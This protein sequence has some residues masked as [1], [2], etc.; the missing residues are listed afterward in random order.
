MAAL[1]EG[2]NAATTTL[3]LVNLNQLQ[4]RTVIVQSGAYA[5]HACQSVS[6]DGHKL[7]VGGPCFKVRLEPGRG[8]KLVLT[9]R[10]Y[11]NVPTLRLPWKR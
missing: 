6:R 1:V 10:R 11:V 4:A 5:E 3:R 8:G 2:F 7:S 9:V